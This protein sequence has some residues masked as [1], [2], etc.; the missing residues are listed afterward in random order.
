MKIALGMKPR[1][2]IFGYIAALI[3]LPLFAWIALIILSTFD[4]SSSPNNWSPYF[5][6][7]RSY[8]CVGKYDG[9]CLIGNERA[10]TREDSI[11]KTL[12]NFKLYYVE[13]PDKNKVDFSKWQCREFTSKKLM[14]VSELAKKGG[15]YEC[16]P[17][18]PIPQE[19]FLNRK[20]R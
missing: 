13:F 1:Y 5:S 18:N 9:S 3:T 8:E 10:W 20:L 14:A 7:Y 6:F 19:L 12:N 15:S 17:N 2:F 16:W 4:T 11:S